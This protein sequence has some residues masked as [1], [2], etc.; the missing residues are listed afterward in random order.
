MISRTLTF[1]PNKVRMGTRPLAAAAGTAC[2]GASGVSNRTDEGPRLEL[3]RSL[4][5]PVPTKAGCRKSPKRHRCSHHFQGR[6]LIFATAICRLQREDPLAATGHAMAAAT[7]RSAVPAQI[8]RLHRYRWHRRVLSQLRV[9]AKACAGRA[10]P[11][12]V[13]GDTAGR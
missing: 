2:H 1:E 4:L 7:P 3:I 13:E 6:R 11:D 8:P 5:V 9:V 12:R 10:T